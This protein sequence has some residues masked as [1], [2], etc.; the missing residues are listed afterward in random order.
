MI[1]AGVL[2]LALGVS[3]QAPTTNVS[4]EIDRALAGVV[5]LVTSLDGGLS[6]YGSGIVLDKK[7]F[8]LTNLHV[9]DGAKAI[10]ALVYDPSRPSYAAIDGGLPR[11]HFEREKE[12]VPVRL[13]RGDPV[14]DLA[15]VRLEKKAPSPMSWLPLASKEPAVGE[16]VS[17]LGHPQQNFWTVTRGLVSGKHQGLIQHDAA[18]NKGNSGGPL[19]NS[20]G[21][22]VGINT[23]YLKDSQGISYARPIALVSKLLDNVQAPLVMDRSTPQKAF[24][25]C[26]HARELAHPSYSQCVNWG[27]HYA[28]VTLRGEPQGLSLGKRDVTEAR[29]V[30]RR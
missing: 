18:V 23:L 10:H 15:V 16:A 22:V 28:E 17:A 9:L 30:G 5:L 27:S 3:A 24:E 26:A 20:A 11:L 12:L 4:P 21:E 6:S 1:A 13:V 7:G 29:R 2:A 8:V 14:L 19:V 25:A